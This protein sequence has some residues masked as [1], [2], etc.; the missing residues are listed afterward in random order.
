MAL[1]DLM[2]H[3]E[4]VNTQIT[5]PTKDLCHNLSFWTSTYAHC[6]PKAMKIPEAK[7]ALD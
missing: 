2:L 5:L 7:A 4:N 6:F 1:G 3:S